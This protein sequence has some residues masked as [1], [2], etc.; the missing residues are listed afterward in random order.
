[1]RMDRRWFWLIVAMLAALSVCQAGGNLSVHFY[2]DTCPRVEKIIHEV[3]A[4][5]IKAAPTTAGGTLRLFFHD[6]FVEGCDGSV[7]I[8]PSGKNDTER[9]AEINKSLAGDAFDVV[10]RAKKAVEEK[11]PGVVSCADVLAIV[12]RDLVVLT[13]G[14]SWPV[15]KGRRDGRVSNISQV[16]FNVPDASFK[17]DQLLHIFESKGLSKEDMVALTGAHTFGFFSL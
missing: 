10:I 8:A 4:E 5:K 1:M 12:S 11:C 14:P 9:E 6:C 3:C 15:T 2:K 13:G 17:L 16:E 7:L